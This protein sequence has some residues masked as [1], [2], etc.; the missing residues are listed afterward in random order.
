MSG[1]SFLYCKSL[2]VELKVN[3]SSHGLGPSL[4]GDG[5]VVAYASRALSKT[6]QKYSQLE[7]KLF[8]IVYECKLYHYYVNRRRFNVM[9]DHHSLETIVRNPIHKAPPKVQILMLQLQP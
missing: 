1:I 6:E 9:T 7:K 3:A 5:E 2:N 8:T 4:C